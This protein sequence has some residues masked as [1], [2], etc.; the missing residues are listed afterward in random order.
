MDILPEHKSVRINHKGIKIVVAQ[1]LV[2]KSPWDLGLTNSILEVANRQGVDDIIY[3][4]AGNT[5]KWN[6]W[7]RY[8]GFIAMN[9]SHCDTDT[10][11]N[12]Y[13]MKKKLK[14]IN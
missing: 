9:S 13:L 8:Y 4:D 11:L 14:N 6:G 12:S 7:N 5:C 10:L 2:P 3:R 1:T